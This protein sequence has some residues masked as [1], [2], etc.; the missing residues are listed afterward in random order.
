MKKFATLVAM[1]IAGG[2]NAFTIG[3]GPLK[4]DLS[5]EIVS[6]WH[7]SM[8]DSKS[9]TFDWGMIN[10]DLGYGGDEFKVGVMLGLIAPGK[11]SNEFIHNEGRYSTE[12]SYINEFYV[13]GEGAFGRVELGRAENINRKIHNQAVDISPLLINGNYDFRM[14]GA[15]VAGINSTA[16]DTDYDRMKVSYITPRMAGL[17]LAGSVMSRE[18][19]PGESDGYIPSNNFTAGFKWT[20]DSDFSFDAAYGQIDDIKQYHLGARK[21]HRGWEVA[22]SYRNKNNIGEAFDFGI[23]YSFGPAKATLATF[24]SYVDGY[25]NKDSVNITL[26][27]LGYDIEKGVSVVGSAGRGAWSREGG[28]SAVGGV[29]VLALKGEF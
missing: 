18:D 20:S 26:A 23:G 2:A 21:F 3:E 24:N 8:A 19:S 9:N 12:N 14:V 28:E 5:G 4:L 17:Q 11:Y 27:S 15:R 29:F 22:S 25:G 1:F 10:A 16:I 7:N 13:Y 6:L